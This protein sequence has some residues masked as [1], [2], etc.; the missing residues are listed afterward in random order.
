MSWIVFIF[1][2]VY[3]TVRLGLS[4]RGQLRYLRL[5]RGLPTRPEPL[6]LPGHLTLGLQRAVAESHATRARL[7][8]AIRA[9]GTV[10]IIDPDVPLGCVRDYRYRMA[11]LSAW[12]AANHCL[13]AFE[14]LDDGDRSR[15][16]AVGCDVDRY[17]HALARLAA[18]FKV[19]KRARALEPFPVDDVRTTCTAVAAMAH[20]LALLEG[21]LGAAPSHPY[22]A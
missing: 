16:E 1:L 18:P 20:E 2:V 14:E 5:R 9:I 17:R 12:S 6:A 22:R 10:L 21:R 15:L 3:G 7:V 11:V 4:I 8:D 13:R 19:A